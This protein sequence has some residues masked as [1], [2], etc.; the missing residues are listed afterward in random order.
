MIRHELLALH[1]SN[2]P[3][4]YPECA[5]LKVTGGQ[6]KTPP[7]SYLVSFPGAYNPNDPSININIYSNVSLSTSSVA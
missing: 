7:S 1:Q 3:Q 5:Q 4:F 6:G 2:V